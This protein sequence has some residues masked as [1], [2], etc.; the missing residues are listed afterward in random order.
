L[1]IPKTVIPPDDVR[2]LTAIICGDPMPGR[3][4]LDSRQADGGT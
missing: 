3:S 1:D 4:A 2:S